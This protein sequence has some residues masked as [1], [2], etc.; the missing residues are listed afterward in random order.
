MTINL[1][2]VVACLPAEEKEK[3]AKWRGIWINP[4]SKPRL[5]VGMPPKVKIPPSLAP[6]SG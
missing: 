4:A 6:F 1:L 5:A 3:V 2:V